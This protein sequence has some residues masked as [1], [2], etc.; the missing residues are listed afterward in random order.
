MVRH[1]AIEIFMSDLASTACSAINP[2]VDGTSE[3]IES[4]RLARYTAAAV[5]VLA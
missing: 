1:G 5:E 2:D 3:Q 4:D